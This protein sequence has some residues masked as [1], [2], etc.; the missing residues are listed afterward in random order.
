M[1]RVA[2][3]G[4]PEP[5]HLDSS[6]DLS[7]DVKRVYIGQA[8]QQ[9]DEGRYTYTF[10][11]ETSGWLLHHDLRDELYWNVTGNDWEF[12]IDQVSVRV[13]LPAGYSRDA[14]EI[15]AWTGRKGSKA[16]NWKLGN[17]T[18]RQEIH[19]ETTTPL[20]RREGFTIGILWPADA[21]Q[22]PSVEET[23]EALLRDNFPSVVALLGLLGSLVVYLAAWAK[24]GKDPEP[25]MVVPRTSPPDLSPAAA[26]YLRRM[27][28]DHNCLAAALVSS[29]SKEAV[30]LEQRNGEFTVWRGSVGAGAV[31]EEDERALVDSLLQGKDSITLNRSNRSK[32]RKSVQSFRAHLKERMVG[33]LFLNNRAWVLPGLVISL[34]SVVVTLYLGQHMEVSAFMVV[35]LTGWSFGVIMLVREAWRAWKSARSGGAYRPLKIFA[36]VFISVFAL[37]FVAGEALGFW[38]LV[39]NSGIWV[40]GALVAHL[41]LAVVFWKLLQA[42][43]AAGRALLDELDAYEAWLRGTLPSRV[44]QAPSSDQMWE[45]F[46]QHLPW[47]IAMASRV[48]GRRSSQ[49]FSTLAKVL[50]AACT[51]TRAIGR[52][53]RQATL[54]ISATASRVRS[55]RRPLAPARQVVAEAPAA[56]EGVVAAAVGNSQ[57]VGTRRAEHSIDTPKG[58]DTRSIA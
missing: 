39:A 23:R 42:P 56:V 32:I 17:I 4:R 44:L 37:P 24:V 28:Y 27:G 26:R 40:A 31:L 22:R 12:P 57:G 41:V 6:G 10:A 47:G 35:W 13:V 3:D 54:S 50:R 7:R 45:L 51:P 43:T 58:S 48:I 9:L 15:D 25:G 38:L 14:L 30:H 20:A 8:N 1:L 21:V 55:P 16:R 5:Y 2:R 29:A 53:T 49:P 46:D 18:S 11:Y 33:K 52:G 19:L 36:A 34:A